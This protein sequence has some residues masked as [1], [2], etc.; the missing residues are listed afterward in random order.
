MSTTAPPTPQN[1]TEIR[2]RRREAAIQNWIE[3]LGR[4]QR[5][6]EAC[7]DAQDR[8]G[9]GDDLAEAIRAAIDT[10]RDARRAEQDLAEFERIHAEAEAQLA[11]LREKIERVRARH[12]AALEKELA[13]LEAEMQRISAQVPPLEGPRRLAGVAQSQAERA[14]ANWPWLF[15]A[16]IPCP[17]TP[18]GRRHWQ[19]ELAQADAEL[20]RLNSQSDDPDRWFTAER[21]RD[22]ARQMLAQAEL[23]MKPR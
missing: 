18:A 1:E 6:I 21:R 9:I 17:L 12:L 7:L 2:D 13:P 22:L 3:L 10:V 8:A 16:S 11:P 5:D 15:D 20:R 19:R 4:P 23:L 14:R